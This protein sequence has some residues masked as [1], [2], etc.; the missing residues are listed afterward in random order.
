MRSRGGAVYVT[1]R[2]EGALRLKRGEH[3]AG[4]RALEEIYADRDP[5]GSDEQGETVAALLER[6]VSCYRL[7]GI[8]AR[9][10]LTD[11]GRSYRSSAHA[12]ARRLGLRQLRTRPNRPRTNGKAERFIQAALREWAYGRLYGSGSERAAALPGSGTRTSA[13]RTAASAT[14]R[15]EHG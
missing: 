1:P 12:L 10:L 2:P 4:R 11:H 7:H 9:S 3:A 14:S 8:V 5:E 13:D 6:A 15:P